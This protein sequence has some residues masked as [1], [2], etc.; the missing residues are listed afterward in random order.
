MAKPLVDDDL[1]LV[2]EPL[3]PKRPPR[4]R[5]SAGRKPIEDRKV[6]TGIV[7]VLSTGIPWE[8]LPKEM[9]CGSGMTC[10][11]RLR[12]WQRA[13]VW[14]RMHGLLLDLL[15]NADKIDWS[16]A[17]V[18]SSHVRA[19]GAGEKDGPLAGGP[20]PTGQQAPRRGRRQRHPLGG[21]PHR[22]QRP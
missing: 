1:W 3:L 18:D 13:G 7:F 10:W 2:I 14:E 20:K 8:M 21:R 4:N 9:G 15:R 11:R 6:L 5:R 16:R 17:A 22:G 19:V 12:D